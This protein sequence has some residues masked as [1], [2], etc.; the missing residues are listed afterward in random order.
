MEQDHFYSNHTPTLADDYDNSKQF[1]PII[2]K[3]IIK[4]IG[5]VQIMVALAL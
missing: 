4:Q 1:H 3:A 5:S 2:M